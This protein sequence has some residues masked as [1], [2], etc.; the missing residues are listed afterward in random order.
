[1]HVYDD[2]MSVMEKRLQLLLDAHRYDLVSSEAK[3]TGRSVASVIRDAID[4]HLE[5]DD[6]REKR[7]AALRA[8][9]DLIE[10]HPGPASGWSQMKAELGED[11]ES[12][13]DRKA[14]LGG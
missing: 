11:L 2:V 14:G 9:L 6:E 4:Q 7:A 10:E 12:Y 3:R 1:M 13:L 5:P 8:F